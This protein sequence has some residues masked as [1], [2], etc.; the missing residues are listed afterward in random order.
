MIVSDLKLA[1]CGV[2]W[3][4]SM[5]VAGVAGFMV[6]HS[7]Q[8][9]EVIEPAPE[10]RQADGSV[11]LERDPEPASEPAP[12]T[13][14]RGHVEERRISVQVQP[15]VSTN[16]TNLDA[17][18]TCECRPVRVDL[19]LARDT[20]GGRRVIASSPDGRVLGGLDVPIVQTMLVTPPKWSA[21]I[22]YDPFDG[23]PGAWIERDYGRIRVGADLYQERNAIASGLAV[24]V[25]IGWTF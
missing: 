13:I 17:A 19:S 18:P 10:V 5:A 11:V 25:R 15:D 23:T 4:L 20:E 2:L 8:A 16:R 1:A 9:P 3:L 7:T 21:G 14:P 24:R 12:H 22:S 6:C